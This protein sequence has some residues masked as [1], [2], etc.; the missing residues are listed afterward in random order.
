MTRNIIV[1]NVQPSDAEDVFAIR[2]LPG[3]YKYFRNPRKIT[4]R[5][6]A[7]W[8]A[9]QLKPRNRR[10]F[11]IATVGGKIAGYLRYSLV[12]DTYD[13]SVAV[14]PQFQKRGIAG[15]LLRQTLPKIETE[16]K[17]VQAEVRKEN[18]ASLRFFEKHGFVRLREKH[19]S[20]IFVNA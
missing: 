5:E 15:F 11:F 4:P 14:V 10:N 7:H 18:I 12:K 16:G 13:I 9:V 8:F 19:D 6:H 1:R 3:I 20:V 17:P 2:N